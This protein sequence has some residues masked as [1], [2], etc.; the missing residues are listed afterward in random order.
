MAG[1]T[2][3][4]FIDDHRD[5]VLKLSTKPCLFFMFLLTIGDFCANRE[6]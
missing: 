4:E 3:F 2:E 6:P 5:E 1:T